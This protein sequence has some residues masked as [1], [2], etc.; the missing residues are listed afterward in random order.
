MPST[1][2]RRL[3]LDPVA[4]IDPNEARYE[5]FDYALKGGERPA[6]LG[7][8]VNYELAGANE[9]RH[10]PS[11]DALDEQ[12]A[13]P[14]PRGL[15]DR[16]RRT[17]SS[18]DKPAAPMALTETL[19]LTRPQRR[20]LA[21]CRRSSSSRRC[22]RADGRSFVS[23]PFAEAID[24]AGRLRG[25]LDFTVNK[26]DV[27]LVVL[28]YEL[29]ANG[30]YVKLFEPAYAFRASYAARSCPPPAAHGGCQAATAV[31]EREDDGPHGS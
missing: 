9:W 21:A 28:L 26:Y 27:D 14:L 24:F 22:S 7:A 25:V 17:R 20:R 11:L 23:E 12:A 2:L 5:W 8:N 13:A 30:E 19:D 15:A 3:T 16:R 10:E 4:R 18:R 1:A 29:R 6:L 31:S